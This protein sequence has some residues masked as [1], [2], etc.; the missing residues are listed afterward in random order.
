MKFSSPFIDHIPECKRKMRRLR[1]KIYK[2]ITSKNYKQPISH[3]KDI[4]AIFKQAEIP[5]FLL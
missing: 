3:K 2:Y 5:S 4:L 1:K